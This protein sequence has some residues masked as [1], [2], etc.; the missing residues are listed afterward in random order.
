MSN[1]MLSFAAPVKEV[2]ILDQ[3]GKP[4]LGGD[5]DRRFFEAPWVHKYNGKYYFSY[6]T[7]DTH[8]IAYATGDSPYGPLLSS[9]IL[10]RW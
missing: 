8:F 1:N 3:A 5:H 2:K 10:K 4:L 7:G 6:S 9:V